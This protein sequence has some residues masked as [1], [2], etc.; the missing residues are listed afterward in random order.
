MKIIETFLKSKTGNEFDCEDSIFI[1]NDFA[2]VIDGVTSKS[3][4]QYNNMLSG[5]VSSLVIKGA[6]NDLKYDSTAEEAIEYLT[7][8]L[9]FLYEQNNIVDYLKTNP[10]ERASSSVVIYSKYKNE[11]WLVGDCQCLIDN[12]HY[13]NKK[14]IDELL[15]NVRALYLETEFKLGNITSTSIEIDPGREFILPLLTRQSL[16][17][18]TIGSKEYSYGVLD[19]FKVPKNEIKTIHLENAKNIVLASDGYPILYSTLRKSENYLQRIIDD[20]P[21]CYKEFKTTKGVTKGNISFDDR[22]YLKIEIIR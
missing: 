17:Q 18:N 6:L 1:S 9:Y 14:Y 12:V 4:R 8:T 22:A 5:K 2:A 11:I 13:T 3:T 15:A 19:G 16:F 21:L 7:D 20:D 10:L